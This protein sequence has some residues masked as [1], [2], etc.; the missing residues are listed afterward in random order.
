MNDSDPLSLL[1]ANLRAQG[2]EAHAR[3][4]DDALYGCTS[5]EIYCYLC[6]G[7]VNVLADARIDEETN[8]LAARLLARYDAVYTSLDQEARA[9][10][11]ADRLGALIA[12]LRAAGHTRDARTL[13][14]TSAAGATSGEILDRRLVE[15]GRLIARRETTL[16]LRD[17]ARL[18]VA[19]IREDLEKAHGT[20]SRR[21]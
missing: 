4:L 12:A 18:V 7:L 16:E 20:P 11:T 3:A 14:A 5:G 17:Q 10:T 8:A 13:R 6:V 21:G 1:I 2:L 15:L 19:S 9:L